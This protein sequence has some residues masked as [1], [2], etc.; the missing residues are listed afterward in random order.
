MTLLF[1]SLLWLFPFVFTSFTSLIKHILWL[2]FSTGERHAG[3]EAIESCSVSSPAGSSFHKY[4]LGISRIIPRLSSSV[5]GR[6]MN[7]WIRSGIKPEAYKWIY[8]VYAV[9]AWA[10]QVVPWSRICLPMQEMQEMRATSWVKKTPRGGNGKPLQYSWPGKLP[11]QSS[12]AGYS[13][14]GRKESAVTACTSTHLHRENMD[15]NNIPE[16]TWRTTRALG[17]NSRC[18]LSQTG[19]NSLEAPGGWRGLRN[20]RMGIVFLLWRKKREAVPE[21]QGLEVEKAGAKGLQGLLRSVGFISGAK[22]SN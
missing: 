2:R 20:E 5:G 4:E 12:L 19:I 8:I 14:W 18:N 21:A 10:S 1:F 7:V 6:V 17:K 22:G 3:G 13:P 16:V 15:G 9:S 11:R